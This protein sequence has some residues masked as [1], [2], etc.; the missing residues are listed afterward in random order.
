[1]IS[2]NHLRKILE[3]CLAVN[4]AQAGN[5]RSAAST[6]LGGFRRAHL[7]HFCKF[8]AVD[9]IG[10]G[11]RRRA[12]PGA[13]DIAVLAQQRG[14]LQTVAQ[15]W[16]GRLR[17]AC[18]SGRGHGVTPRIFLGI[19]CKYRLKPATMHRPQKRG[20]LEQFWGLRSK[21]QRRAVMPS[22]RD[23][24]KDQ[25]RNLEISG[26]RCFASPR[27]DDLG[28][29]RAAHIGFAAA[30]HALRRGLGVCLGGGR[31]GAIFEVR[32]GR[33]FAPSEP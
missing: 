27:N 30:D 11:M 5:A 14:I 23:G 20:C 22:F 28:S 26:L 6:A 17:S 16:R 24:P 9:R 13:V 18:G 3:R 33:R 1:M 15:R 10:H 2:S 12:D 25:T 32:Q 21:F 8:D 4:F 7:R 31:A 19:G 29:G